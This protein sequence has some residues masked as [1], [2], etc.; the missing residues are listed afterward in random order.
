MESDP[1][2]IFTETDPRIRI[3]IKMK[4]IRNTYFNWQS[5]IVEVGV[6]QSAASVLPQTAASAHTVQ[7]AAT[8]HAA[9]AFIQY[10]GGGDKVNLSSI[11]EE[12]S[13]IEEDDQVRE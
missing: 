11:V 12:Q 5:C 4:R 1:D 7:N 6:E 13:S 8:I 9:G 2:P 3:R 10:G